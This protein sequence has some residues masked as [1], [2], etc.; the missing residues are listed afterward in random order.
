[1]IEIEKYPCNDSLEVRARERF[2][3]EQLNGTL[4]SNKPCI[5]D[6]ELKVYFTEY[7][8]NNKDKLLNYQAEYFKNNKNKLYDYKKQK[9]DCVCGGK[10]T[11]CHKQQHLKSNKHINFINK[12]EPSS[13]TTTTKD[14]IPLTN[15]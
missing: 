4:N 3:R 9:Q 14:E 7:F 1:M 12:M 10:Y 5:A 11:N 6:S 13:Y 2:W 15:E 8:K